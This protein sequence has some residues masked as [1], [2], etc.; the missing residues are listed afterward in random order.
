MNTRQNDYTDA[1]IERSQNMLAAVLGPEEVA[2]LD[3]ESYPGPGHNQSPPEPID[4]ARERVEQ[5]IASA[6]A[7]AAQVKTVENEETAT[8]LR[9]KLQQ[10]GDL[11]K[12]YDEQRAAERKPHT[13]AA[14]AVQAKWLPL[15]NRIATCRKALQPLET[16]WLMLLRNRQ[17]AER[18][19][20]KKEAAEAEARAHQLADLALAGGPSVATNLI[21]A[22]EAADEADAAHKAVSAVPL[23]AQ[24]RDAYGG[25]A[26]SLHQTWSATII[27]QDLLYRHFRGH[28]D[29]TAVLQKL[30]N[31]AVRAKD[32]PR[33]ANG[34]KEGINDQL[35]GILIYLEER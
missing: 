34:A 28:A 26:R 2:R 15:L 5:E 14:A 8:T 23:R 22:Q 35:P 27:D 31:A 25:R 9:T 13:E 16:T 6:D 19:R 21:A 10:L 24:T 32:G 4:L 1:E 18:E 11:W 33:P 29:V 12:E 20:L 3:A 17:D 30:A 7:W